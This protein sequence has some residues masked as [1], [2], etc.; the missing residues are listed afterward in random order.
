M[1]VPDWVELEFSPRFVETTDTIHKHKVD[2][3]EI[4]KI[5]RKEREYTKK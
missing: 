1:A 3:A 2:L 5:L 4:W